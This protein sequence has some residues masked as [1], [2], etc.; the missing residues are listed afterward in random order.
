M[1]I[2]S[3][4]NNEIALLL[5]LGISEEGY[6]FASNIQTAM[7]LAEL[8]MDEINSKLNE[9]EN[10]LKKL[11]PECDKT[12]YILAA[13]SG[14]ICGLMDIFLVGKAG[15]S[16]IGDITDNCL[17]IVLWILLSFVVGME[18]TMILFPQQ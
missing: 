6:E 2:S 5:D 11:T 3:E 14:A 8:E 9:N 13:A 16:V 15:E 7:R 1:D 4:K 12:D 18:I 10:T 17:K